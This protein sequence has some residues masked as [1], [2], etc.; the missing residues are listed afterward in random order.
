MPTASWILW[1]SLSKKICLPFPYTQGMAERSVRWLNAKLGHSVSPLED[2]QLLLCIPQ[3]PWGCPI[4]LCSAGSCPAHTSSPLSGWSPESVGCPAMTQSKNQTVRSH[5][6]ASTKLEEKGKPQKKE[7]KK[8]NQ[9]HDKY[10][11]NTPLKTCSDIILPFISTHQN[12]YTNN[13]WQKYEENLSILNLEKHNVLKV[14]TNMI[15][16]AEGIDLVGLIVYILLS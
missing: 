5:V 15:S 14:L 10:L 2:S 12:W 8:I 1:V 3:Q 9:S 13:R 11:V 16:V 6:E 7:G 4:A